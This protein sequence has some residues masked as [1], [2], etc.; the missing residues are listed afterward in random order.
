MNI[1]NSLIQLVLK[2]NE[3]RVNFNEAIDVRNKM[4]KKFRNRFRWQVWSIEKLHDPT[5]NQNT[6]FGAYSV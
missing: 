4:L 5:I 3:D 1:T 6:L 2:V